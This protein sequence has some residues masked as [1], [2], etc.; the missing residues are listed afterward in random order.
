MQKS[1]H[2]KIWFSGFLHVNTPMCGNIHPLDQ[3]IEHCENTE[4]FSCPLLVTTP[5]KDNH[6][7]DF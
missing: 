1:K 6:Y 3:E 4:V 5:D 2:I 7:P